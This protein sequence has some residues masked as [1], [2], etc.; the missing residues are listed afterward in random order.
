[1]MR[2]NC[3]DGAIPEVTV[4]FD[5]SWPEVRPEYKPARLFSLL[6]G[7]SILPLMHNAHFSPYLLHNTVF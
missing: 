6:P 7:Y 5:F 1:M 2:G 4:E 3:P